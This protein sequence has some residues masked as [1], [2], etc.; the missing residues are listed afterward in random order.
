MQHQAASFLP[1]RARLQFYLHGRAGIG[2]SEFVKVFSN[3]LEQLIQ[4]NLHPTTKV[5]PPSPPPLG[6]A[7]PDGR[8]SGPRGRRR[9]RNHRDRRTA[10]DEAP[11]TPLTGTRMRGTNIKD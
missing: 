3:G 11:R 5:P 6:L 2:K 1:K 9:S 8:Q 10:H 7:P 4:K